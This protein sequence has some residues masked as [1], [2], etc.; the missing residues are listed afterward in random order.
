MVCR[1]LARKVVGFTPSSNPTAAP[2]ALREAHKALCLC[3]PCSQIG[4][5]AEDVL[6]G[7]ASVSLGKKKEIECKANEAHIGSIQ[8]CKN[9]VF[10]HFSF[11]GNCSSGYIFGRCYARG[12]LTPFVFRKLFT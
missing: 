2:Q 6:A 12:Q 10:Q 5:P 7:L 1:W 3:Q 4:H 11:H 8:T 9:W